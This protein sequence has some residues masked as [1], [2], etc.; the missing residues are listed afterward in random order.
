MQKCKVLMVALMVAMSMPLFAQSDDFG[1][2]FSLEAQKKLSKQWSMS[3]EGEYRTRDNTKTSDRWA[4]GL[5]V[6]YK[7]AKW[8]KASAGYTFL[9]DNNEKISYFDS[10]DD[11]VLDGDANAG[12]PKK[13]AQYWAP[14]HR[15][16]VSLT[17]D[18]KLF[19][20]F[21][22]SLRERWQYTYRP[23]HTVSERWSYLDNAYD[24]KEKTYT[25]KGK[26]VLRSRLQVEYDKKGL[27][28]TPY[29]NVEL[30]N[31]WSLQKVRYNVGL[32][33]KLSKQHTIGAF[34]RYQNVRND[35]DDNEPNTHLIGV[36]YKFKF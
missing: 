24:G 11:A 20:D 30:F 9:Y 29:A 17:F 3:L 12:D 31:A 1:L 18:K 6:D 13:C 19:G 32:D 35:D 2:D 34:Y 36:G 23:A 21:R 4:I 27:A 22:F 16:N 5:G 7:V 26:N 28:V 8:L 33:W 25:G 15:F 10:T 14:R